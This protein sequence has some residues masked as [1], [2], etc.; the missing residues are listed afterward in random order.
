MPG[1]LRLE[2]CLLFV[3]S[4]IARPLLCG[5]GAWGLGDAGWVASELSCCLLLLWEYKYKLK[6][7]AVAVGPCPLST[8]IPLWLWQRRP[9]SA[10]GMRRV[11]GAWIVRYEYG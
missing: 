10:M 8:S 4:C 1:L 7:R 6:L 11:V 3:V 2:C 9:Y 5:L